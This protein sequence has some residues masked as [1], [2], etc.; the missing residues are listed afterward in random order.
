MSK[1]TFSILF[2]WFATLLAG[3]GGGTTETTTTTSGTGTIGIFITDNPITDGTIKKVCVTYHKVEVMGDGRYTAYQGDAITFDLLELRDHARPLA[4]TTVPVGTYNKVRLTLVNDGIDLKLDD[5]DCSTPSSESAYPHLPGNNKLDFVVQDGMVVV[6]DSKVFYEFDM[7]AKKA[8]HVVERSSGHCASN[9][10]NRSDSREMGDRCLQFNFRP[11]VFIHAI[12]EA[13]EAKL[14]RLVGNIDSVDPDDNS[15]VLCG[16][17]PG[18][19]GMDDDDPTKC[20]RVRVSSD[21]SFFDIDGYPQ[22]LDALQEAVGEQAT[23]NGMIWVIIRPDI[24]NGYRPPPGQCRIWDPDL[25]PDQQSPPGNCA[26]LWGLVQEGEYLIRHDEGEDVYPLV[27]EALTIGLG[28]TR[29][30]TGDVVSPPV[31]VPD[32]STDEQFSMDVNEAAPL[33]VR[34][35]AGVEG[36]NGTRIIDE[37]GNSLSR[38]VLIPPRPVRVDGVSVTDALMRGELV[39]LL[40]EAFETTRLSGTIGSVAADGSSFMLVLD[41]TDPENAE[42]VPTLSDQSVTVPLEAQILQVNLGDGTTVPLT[43]DQLAVDQYINLYA[44]APAD[45][46]GEWVA[47]TVVVISPVTAGP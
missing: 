28:E 31:A 14:I 41:T 13:Y 23:V 4:F 11:V 21:D 19:E 5:S 3:C 45:G 29:V 36:G 32:D 37:Q 9:G 34:L 30:D 27:V 44:V 42:A 40:D 39:V 15:L 26:D 2:L 8:I 17:L 16:A 24:P 46:L 33:A 25:Q 20:V 12:T 43:R 18:M 6:P 22:P 47:E 35:Q 10:G 1:L 38:N 7:D